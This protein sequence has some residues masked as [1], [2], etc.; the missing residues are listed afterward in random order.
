MVE[1]KCETGKKKEK[2]ETE[3]MNILQFYAKAGILSSLPPP[4]ERRRTTKDD[5]GKIKD[6]FA[7]LEITTEEL[8]DIFVGDLR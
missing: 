1:T 8:T 5:D 4:F 2:S 3:K 7:E 6:I